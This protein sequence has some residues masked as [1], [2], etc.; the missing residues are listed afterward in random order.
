MNDEIEIKVSG[1]N[2]MV[3]SLNNLPD[4]MSA[5]LF[6]RFVK[7]DLRKNVKNKL[8]SIGTP[9]NKANSAAI[10]T[11][12][13]KGKGSA[14]AGIDSRYFYYYFLDLGTKERYTT[15]KSGHA[16][17]GKIVPNHSISNILDNAEEPIIKYMEENILRSI[18]KYMISKNKSVMKKLI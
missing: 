4:K 12:G 18:D 16:Y 14:I 11:K 5:S 2:E 3:E 8:R 13:T 6:S 15:N 10:V 9:Y 17:R 1:L 7:E